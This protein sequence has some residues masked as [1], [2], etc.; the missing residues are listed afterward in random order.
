MRAMVSTLA[1][2]H[3]FQQAPY[4][5]KGRYYVHNI[6]FSGLKMPHMILFK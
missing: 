4:G 5:T 2:T 3:D 1:H 6:V